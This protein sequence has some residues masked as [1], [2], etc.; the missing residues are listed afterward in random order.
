MTE[1]AVV[2]FT[3]C[4]GAM[5]G[6][7]DDRGVGAGVALRRLCERAGVRVIVPV[8]IDRLCCGTPWRSKGLDDGADVMAART[9]ES[10]WEASEGGRWPIVTDAAS[11]THGLRLSTHHLGDDAKERL[12]ILHII[13]GVTFA[14]ALLPDLPPVRTRVGSLALHPT[15]STEHLGT[16]DDLIALAEGVA[17]EVTVPAEWG[18]CG[19]AGD[20]GMLHPELTAAAT[21]REA[22]EVEAGSF[23]AWASCNRTCEMGMQRATGRRYEH[24]LEI[25]E[26]AT[27]E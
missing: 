26:R 4:V 19:Y 24:I 11:C 12:A 6:P 20:R 9:M 25:L 18:C 1:Q 13:D 5:F 8:D 10:L 2:L 3:S 15:C 14:R 17:D 23:D 16:T 22:A 21:A 27:R 7:A